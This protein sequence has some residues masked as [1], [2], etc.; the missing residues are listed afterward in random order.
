MTKTTTPKMTPPD[1][2]R[3]N[4][5]RS[6]WAQIAVSAFQAAHGTDDENVLCDLLCD[7]MHWADRHNYDF[8]A[9]L[10]RAQDHYEAETAGEAI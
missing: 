7:L 9:A 3:M 1:P 5:R 4:D 8:P 10:V 6:A 2:E